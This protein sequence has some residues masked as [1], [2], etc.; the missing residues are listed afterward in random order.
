MSIHGMTLFCDDVREEKSGKRILIGLYADNLV[1]P[2]F[3]ID[4]SHLMLVNLIRGPNGAVPRSLAIK[5]SLP[6]DHQ[7]V[8]DIPVDKLTRDGVFDR[9]PDGILNWTLEIGLPLPAIQ[10]TGPGIITAE[11]IIDGTPFVTGQ[12]NVQAAVEE[13]PPTP[14]PTRATGKRRSKS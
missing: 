6:P 9:G 13:A 2:G 12:M 4:L 10:I 5:L 3:P 11:I 1:V 7:W 8:T 14:T